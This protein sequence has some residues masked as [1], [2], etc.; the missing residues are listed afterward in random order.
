MIRSLALIALSSCTLT[1]THGIPVIEGHTIAHQDD[2]IR[3]VSDAYGIDGM[4]DARILW[5]ADT[6][7]VGGEEVTAIS[8]GGGCYWGITFWCG[9]I[10]VA[11]RDR[12]ADTALVHELAHCAR[13]HQYGPG[14]D[15]GD[16]GHADV[17][18]WATAAA[19]HDL[20][21]ELGW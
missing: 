10:Y 5:S 1:S 7:L 14:P 3:L 4:P 21:G 6:C 2:V 16:R 13:I 8:Y 18:W 9:E 15:P 19:M 20:I 11:V 17:V 12:I